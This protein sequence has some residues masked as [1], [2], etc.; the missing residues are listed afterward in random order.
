MPSLTKMLQQCSDANIQVFHIDGATAR[1]ARQQARKDYNDSPRMSRMSFE[2]W[3]NEY[4]V[5]MR[6]GYY[7]W[8]CC[9]GCL[10]DSDAFGPFTSATRAAEDATSHLE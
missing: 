2:D 9:P 5:A 1:V 6:A 4:G 3:A 8:T 7:W 10:P